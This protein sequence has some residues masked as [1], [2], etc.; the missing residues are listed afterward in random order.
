MSTPIPPPSSVP[1]EKKETDLK[2][3]IIVCTCA[4]LGMMACEFFVGVLALVYVL[5]QLHSVMRLR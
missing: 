4:L 1:Q 5:S 3:T 2:K